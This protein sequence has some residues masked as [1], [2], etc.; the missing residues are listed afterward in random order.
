MPMS[1]KFTIIYWASTM[2]QCTFLW[3][4]FLTFHTMKKLLYFCPVFIWPWYGY[5]AALKLSIF[6]PQPSEFWEYS[7]PP[8]CLATAYIFFFFETASSPG[9]LWI[10]YAAKDTLNFWSPCLNPPSA[11]I[12]TI[13]YHPQL[14]EEPR[15]FHMQDKYPTNWVTSSS[16]SFHYWSLQAYVVDIC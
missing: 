14:G 7:Q 13:H 12:T 16:L 9:W 4:V 1:C 2:Y 10:T 11:R 6:L 5:Q 8:S 15:A 3:Y